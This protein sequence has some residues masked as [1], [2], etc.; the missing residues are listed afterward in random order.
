[1][2]YEKMA[3]QKREEKMQQLEGVEQSL[4][5]RLGHVQKM[6]ILTG[7][8]DMKDEMRNFLESYDPSKPITSDDIHQ[9]FENLAKKRRRVE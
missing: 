2:E 9:V 8:A 6:E 4:L 5:N 7:I 1:M 3:K